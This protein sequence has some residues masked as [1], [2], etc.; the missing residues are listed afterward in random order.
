MTL[1]QTINADAARRLTGVTQ[2]TNSMSARQKWSK[3]HSIR[4]TIISHTYE[5][6]S[7]KRAQ[8]VTGDLENHQIEKDSLHLHNF[9]NILKQNCNPFNNE[10]IERE[11]LYNIGTGRAAS[12]EVS[13]FLLNV[14]K[15]DNLLKEKFITECAE[16]QD[17]FEQAIKL[18]KILNFASATAKKKVTIN[19]KIQKVK[20][21]RDLFGRMLAI[22]MNDATDIQ[23]ILTYPLTPVPM[24]LCHLDG[25]IFKTVKAALIK[26]LDK[27]IPSSAPA[28]TDVCL[29]DGFYLIYCMKDVP[30][31]FGNI[32]K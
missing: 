20:L 16:S 14:E 9:I 10:N 31:T 21:Q 7:L 23:K 19:N 8:D 1:E 17:R 13:D 29:I 32:S 18:T 15:N 5:K 3:S 27:N 30:K 4:S 2:F 6:T 22:S 25:S 12:E 24:T 28:H 11:F 26:L